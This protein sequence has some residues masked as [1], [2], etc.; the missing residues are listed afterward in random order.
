MI[1]Q[2]L[3]AARD[4]GGNPVC[5]APLLMEFITF[6]EHE[7]IPHL[8]YVYVC[9]LVLL[10]VTISRLGFHRVIVI[11]SLCSCSRPS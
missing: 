10:H 5:S 6:T 8:V 4:S 2:Y 3:A 9:H 1:V 7:Y 11:A